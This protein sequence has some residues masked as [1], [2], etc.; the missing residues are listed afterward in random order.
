MKQPSEIFLGNKGSVAR[1]D[2]NSHHAIW[3][4]DIGKGW[5]P[6]VFST[7]EDN[8]L[9]QYSNIWGK[10]MLMCMN[11][12]TGQIK[13]QDTEILACV[14]LHFIDKDLFFIGDKGL[15]KISLESGNYDY[16]KKFAGYFEAA[17][18][19]LNIASD[20]NVYLISNKKTLIVDKETGLT[21]EILDDSKSSLNFKPSITVSHG[22]GVDQLS[23]VASNSDGGSGVAI[24]GDGGGGGGE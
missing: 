4:V 16:Q 19:A 21:K 22:L 3:S 6:K 7:Y 17:G 13:W 14:Q 24:A 2:M 1:Y 9:V 15:N 8:L 10:V 20:K 23:I 18:F 12:I 5:T 11:S